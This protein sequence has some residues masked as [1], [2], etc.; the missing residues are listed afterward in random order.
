M[1]G[2]HQGIINYTI[3]Q[4]KG[5]GITFGEP[6]FVISKNAADNTVTLGKSEDLFSDTLYA[7]DVNWIMIE[8]L[9]EPMRV[10]IKA[11]YKQPEAD[12]TI[13]PHENGEVKA[14]FDAP[15]RAISPG[16]SVVFYLGDYGV[17]G[18]IIK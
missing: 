15:I 8:G 10:K 11:R 4:R 13:Y 12:G 2:E 3:G 5:L 6:V 18:G 1:L 7:K 14:V 16:Q 9:K 17:G